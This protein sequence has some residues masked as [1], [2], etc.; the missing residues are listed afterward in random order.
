V[1]LALGS[2]S[3]YGVTV[4]FGRDLAEA[5]LGAPTTLGIRFGIGSLVL[6]TVLL[7]TG[8]SPVPAR[9]ERVAAF[10]LGAVGY[11]VESSFFFLGLERGTAAA[12]ALLFYAFPAMV[13]GF[14]WVT[15]AVRM[16]RR[17]ACGVAL[18]MTGVI[19]VVAT[20]GNVDI[21]P[22]GVVFA[23]LAALSFSIYLLASG[24][25]VRRTDPVVNAAWVSGG[26]S[27]SLLTRGLVTSSLRSPE[28]HLPALA[29][30]GLA[31]AA[32]FGLMF[33]ALQRIGPT[34]TAVVMTFEAFASAGLA[35]IFLGESLG[36]G[37]AVG[38]A[39]IIAGAVIVTSRTAESVPEAEV[40]LP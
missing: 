6:F 29:C 32:A 39:A 19:V 31:N 11:A 7:A 37:Q 20:G 36:P 12:V 3:A 13:L 24:R 30:N 23:L 1:L 5:G 27:L 4:V 15:G 16:N 28:G 9:G 35:A 38:G 18:S 33:A 17:L 8:R 10:L 34:R 26:A 22:T 25:L 14:E 40:P 2:A 21:S